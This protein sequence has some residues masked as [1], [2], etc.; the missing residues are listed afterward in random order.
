MH[1]HLPGR[2]TGGKGEELAAASSAAPALHDGGARGN[3]SQPQ[4]T[5]SGWK[6]NGTLLQM[7]AQPYIPFTG[8]MFLDFLVID[9]YV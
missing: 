7:F 5:V 4:C 9:L 1:F 6:N 8:H 3:T 2:R